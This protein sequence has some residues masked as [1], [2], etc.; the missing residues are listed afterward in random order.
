M[1]NFMQQ[2]QKLS[3]TDYLH[4]ARKLR[5][6]LIATSAPLVL[7]HGDLHHD[8]ILQNGNEWMVIDPKGV[9]GEPAYEAAAFIRNPIPEL[10]RH[11]NLSSIVDNRITQ[12]AEI[13]ELSKQRIISWCYVQSVLAWAWAFFTPTFKKWGKLKKCTSARWTSISVLL[14]PTPRS[15]SRIWLRRP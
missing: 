10:L 1:I 12:F 6:E 13:L 11:K 2:F 5:D 15:S 9:I 14:S 4:K 8:N 7:I 3:H